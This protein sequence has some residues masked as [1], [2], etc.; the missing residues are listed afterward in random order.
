MN[1][2]FII[3]KLKATQRWLQI[4]IEIENSDCR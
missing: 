4:L 2:A 1:Y 3:Q